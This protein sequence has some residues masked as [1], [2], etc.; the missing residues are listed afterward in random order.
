MGNTT[1]GDKQYWDIA[2]EAW[3][4][5]KFAV[6]LTALKKHKEHFP[7]HKFATIT[8]AIILGEMA[9]FTQSCAILEQLHP[10]EL[11]DNSLEKLYYRQLGH[12]H[13]GLGN[14]EQAIHYYDQS[15]KLDPESTTGYIFKG[16]CLRRHGAVDAA[17]EVF[18]AATHLQPDP[19]EAFL[20]LA[21]ISRTELDL[22]QAKSYCEQALDINPDYPEAQ[23]CLEDIQE[24]IDMRKP[25]PTS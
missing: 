23:F 4:C 25:N 11:E 14:F 15:I 8:Q 18:L 10:K 6:A 21:L 17:K 9:A 1:N 22:E 13:S 2:I 24:A 20:N 7:D 19:E 16:D 3:D 12:N 5:S